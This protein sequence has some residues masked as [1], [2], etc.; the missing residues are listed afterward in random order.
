MTR[1]PETDALEALEATRPRA[2]RAASASVDGAILDADADGDAEV[3]FAPDE[4]AEF[5]RRSHAAQE[6]QP[7]AAIDSNGTAGGVADF[8]LDLP[9][10]T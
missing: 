6:I 5:Q 10:V 7:P 1:P 2:S 8:A 9:K 3:A 4:L